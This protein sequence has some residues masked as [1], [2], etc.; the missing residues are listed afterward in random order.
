MRASNIDTIY[1]I[2]MILAMKTAYA[3]RCLDQ[4]IGFESGLVI[5]HSNCFSRHSFL[6]SYT[7]CVSICRRNRLNLSTSKGE[8]DG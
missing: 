8:F 2:D 6:K 4:H 7:A 1:L 3:K 5:A